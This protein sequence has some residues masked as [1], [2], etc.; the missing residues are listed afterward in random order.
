[1]SQGFQPSPSGAHPE[2]GGADA[3]DAAIVHAEERRVMLR[4]L[5]EIGM[6]IARGIAR[7]AG[8]PPDSATPAAP[9]PRHD[10]PSHSPASPAPSA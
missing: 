7:R 1:M 9:A 5:A 10:P 2:S 8:E 3:T 4:D 6:D